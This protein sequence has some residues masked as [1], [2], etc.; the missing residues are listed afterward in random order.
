MP[1]TYTLISSVTVGAGGASSIDFSSIPAT[2]T[3]L[4]VVLSGRSTRAAVNCNCFLTFNGSSAAAYT[5]RYLQGDGAAATSGNDVS[6]TSVFFGSLPGTSVTASTFGNLEIYIPNYAGSNNKSYSADSVIENNAT[7]ALAYLIAGL[8]ANTAAI[9]SISLTA[10][11]FNFVQYSNAY[12]YG[13]KN[14]QEIKW[15]RQ[16]SQLIAKQAKSQR[17]N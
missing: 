16:K 2:Y 4:K 6:A 7:S 3:D 15:Q 9:T 8:W 5:D 14:S 13:I 1:N 10:S 11:G 17:L 12:L